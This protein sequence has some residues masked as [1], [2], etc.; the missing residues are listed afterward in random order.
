[1]KK[2]YLY[3]LLLLTVVSCRSIIIDQEISDKQ[4]YKLY[5]NAGQVNVD[6][7]IQYNTDSTFV[8]CIDRVDSRLPD[9]KYSFVVLSLDSRSV[10]LKSIKEYSK[11]EWLD[12]ENILLVNYLGIE[13]FDKEKQ[14]YSGNKIRKIY[15]INSKQISNFK[16]PNQEIK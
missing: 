9:A 10:N 14:T 2:L 11:I 12:N 15:N 6:Y 1:M 5:K 7:D 8:I 4:A 3:N 13:K 16:E